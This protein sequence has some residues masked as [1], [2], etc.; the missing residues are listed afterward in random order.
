MMYVL[1]AILCLKLVPH[2]L[3]LISE[4]PWLLPKVTMKFCAR[5]CAKA[6]FALQAGASDTLKGLHVP[7]TPSI[8]T[9][10]TLLYKQPPRNLLIYHARWS[11][12]QV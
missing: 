3:L 9:V 5:A 2:L 10:D 4:W 1:L 12:D 7:A 8:N 11:S 6:R